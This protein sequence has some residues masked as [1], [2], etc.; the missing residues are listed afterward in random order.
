MNLQPCVF[1][2]YIYPHVYDVTHNTGVTLRCRQSDVFN[3]FHKEPKVIL[4]YKAQYVSLTTIK[5]IFEQY[6]VCVFSILD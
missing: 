2:I 1:S 4:L 5:Y 3:I 6:Y